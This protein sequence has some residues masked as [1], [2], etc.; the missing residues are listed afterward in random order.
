MVY[1][2]DSGMSIISKVEPSYSEEARKAKFQGTVVLSVTVGTDGRASHIQVQRSL[3]LG[4]DEKAIEAVKQWRFKPAYSQASQWKRQPRWRSRHPL[5]KLA[6]VMPL[7][8]APITSAMAY[9]PYSR[10]ILPQTKLMEV[11]GWNLG[12]E[13]RFANVSTVR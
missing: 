9:R 3:G 12:N 7:A 4:L 1:A 8:R 5:S 10:M 2:P 6:R 11:N 13:C